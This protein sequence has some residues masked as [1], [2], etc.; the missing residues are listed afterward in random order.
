MEEKRKE[1]YRSLQLFITSYL[2]KCFTLARILFSKI[3]CSLR[4][5]TMSNSLPMYTLSSLYLQAP[6]LQI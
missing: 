1:K 2:M 5:S 3:A 4:D 6:C